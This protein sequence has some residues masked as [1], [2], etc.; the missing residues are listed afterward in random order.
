MGSTAEV[1]GLAGGHCKGGAFGLGMV[2][3]CGQFVGEMS[4]KRSILHV[5]ES[6]D[7]PSGCFGPYQIETLIEESEE[8]VATAYRVRIHAHQVTA[9]SYHKVAEELYYVISGS[10]VA[11]LDG[12]PRELR[13]GDFLRLP[14]GT[15]HGFVTR[16]EDLVMLDI[17]SPGSRPNRDVYFEGEAPEGFSAG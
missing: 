10:G 17:H 5:R 7:V 12:V 8:G 16:E 1:V 2:V 9:I 14:P 13:S 6:D 3:E 15:K 4:S 11:V